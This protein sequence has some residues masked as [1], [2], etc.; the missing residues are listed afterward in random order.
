M[1]NNRKCKRCGEK[2]G[3]KDNF[4]ASCGVPLSQNDKKEDMGMLGKSDSFDENTSNPPMPGFG[5]KMLNNMLSGAIKMLE[6]EM[7]REMKDMEKKKSQNKQQPMNPAPNFKLKINGQEVNFDDPQANQKKKETKEKKGRKEFSKDQLKKYQKLPKEEPQA[8]LK[9]F[10]NKV[11]YEVN[12]PDVKSSNDI[13]M[14]DLE[15]SIEIKAVGK[16]KGYS[17][18]IPVN[19]PVTNQ[20]LY[21]GKLILELEE[22][23]QQG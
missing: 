16:N 21:D 17:K 3:K 4:C 7:Q 13:I 23:Q 2:I 6:K 20:R 22:N 12:M 14:N 19:M 8:D 11:V 1:F 18:R 10:G 15:S 5:G 9:R